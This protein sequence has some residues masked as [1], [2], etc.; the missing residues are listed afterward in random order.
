MKK[1][2]LSLFHPGVFAIDVTRLRFRMRRLGNREG[3][4]DEG[5]SFQYGPKHT[6]V[7]TLMVIPTAGN[8]TCNPVWPLRFVG[9]GCHLP[10]LRPRHYADLPKMAAADKPSPHGKY[11]SDGVLHMAR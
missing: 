3:G 4:Q 6:E 9:N 10:T 2:L 8:S 5:Q 7:P 11:D 1:L